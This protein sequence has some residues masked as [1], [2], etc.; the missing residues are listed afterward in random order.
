MQKTTFQHPGGGGAAP[1]CLVLQLDGVW[2]PL[3]HLW[4]PKHKHKHFVFMKIKHRVQ[5]AASLPFPPVRTMSQVLA[6]LPLGC[7]REWPHPGAQP[8][9]TVNSPTNRDIHP[10][11]NPTTDTNACMV[12]RPYFILF[13]AGMQVHLRCVICRLGQTFFLIWSLVK[14]TQAVLELTMYWRWPSTSAG[15]PGPEAKAGWVQTEAQSGKV[16]E[17]LTPNRNKH[18][19]AGAGRITYKRVQVPSPAH[20]TYR[21]TKTTVGCSVSFFFF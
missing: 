7:T 13:C 3:W 21:S 20:H 1:N 17:I 6:R 11:S 5:L 15:I 14:L 9:P 4:A 19:G 10:P 16:R 18:Q 8:L 2:C 12:S